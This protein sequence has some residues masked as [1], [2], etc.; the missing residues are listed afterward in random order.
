MVNNFFMNDLETKI[1]QLEKKIITIEFA[2][3]LGRD[4]PIKPV[5]PDVQKVAVL[6]KRL[7]AGACGASISEIDGQLRWP[8]IVWARQ[9]AMFLTVK[10]SGAS[11]SEVKRQF[12][13]KDHSTISHACKKVSDCMETEPETKSMVTALLEAMKSFDA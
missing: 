1:M 2:L 7:A 5:K 9:V 3:G 12:G 11:W 8:R 13:K 10:T 4:V 6:A